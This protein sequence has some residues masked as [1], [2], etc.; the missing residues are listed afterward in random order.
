MHLYAEMINK[1]KEVNRQAAL[2]MVRK[3]PLINQRMNTLYGRYD[4]D[5]ITLTPSASMLT[6]AFTWHNTPQGYDYWKSI[7]DKINH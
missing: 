2:I 7:S 1:V 5:H 4:S 3:L 6:E